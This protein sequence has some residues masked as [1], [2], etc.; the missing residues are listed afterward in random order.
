MREEG[1]LVS[2]CE[3]AGQS[4]LRVCICVLTLGRGRLV[5]HLYLPFR[6]VTHEWEEGTRRVMLDMFCL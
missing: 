3:L 6:L 5:L 2:Y 4:F 1:L